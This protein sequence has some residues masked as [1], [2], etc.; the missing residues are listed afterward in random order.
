MTP[1]FRPRA[2]AALFGGLPGAGLRRGAP[3]AGLVAAALLGAASTAAADDPTP[4]MRYDWFV[5]PMMAY[6]SDNGVGFGARVEVA[7]REPGYQ[8]FRAAYMAQGYASLRSYHHHMLRYDRIGLGSDRLRLT[9]NGV[10]RQWGN[11]GYWGIGNA[12]TRERQYVGDF[13]DDDPRGERYEYS[14][15]QPFLHVTLRVGLGS[16]PAAGTRRP[17]A[18]FTSFNGKWS[19]VSAHR[20]S[21]L[22]EDQPWGVEGGL[23]LLVTAG[24]LYDTRRPEAD[25]QR[26]IFAEVSLSGSIPN[27]SGS[28]ALFALHGAAR[29]YHALLPWMVAAGRV[30]VEAMFGRVPFYEMVHWHGSV[31]I[32]GFGGFDAVRGVPFGRW[33]APHRAVASV[34]LRLR[35]ARITVFRRSLA[36]QLGLFT[37]AGIV[38]GAGEDPGAEAQFPLHVTGGA[39]L[40]LVFAET[41][42]GRFD[43]GFGN[44]PIR[45][46]SGELSDALS[47]GIYLTFGQAF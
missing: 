1:S 43:T 22:A 4:V 24:L 5:V 38:W 29:A 20:D 31:P 36:L 13:D 34:E 15:V 47:L 45:E 30:M 41:F 19:D 21:L 7:R 25:P 17:W 37:D 23:D 27:S 33:R 40:R 46:A 12:T 14:L 3:V 18:I 6:N 8:P 39:G 16:R 44:D 10:Y 11:D 28:A 26:G 42:V 35:L 2:F 9:V 32:A